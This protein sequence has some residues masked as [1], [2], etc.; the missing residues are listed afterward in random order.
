MRKVAQEKKKKYIESGFGNKQEFLDTFREAERL[1]DKDYIDYLPIPESIS[2]FF[3]L[4]KNL[5]ADARRQNAEVLL[6]GLKDVPWIT[7]IF[8][9]LGG[10]DVPLCVPVLVE[11]T[12]RNS[13][14]KHL[15][16]HQIYCP[17]HWPVSELHGTISPRTEK[18]Y[19]S[20]LSLVCDQRYDEEDMKHIIN[21]IND[22]YKVK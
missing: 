6:K 5:I 21:C 4:D 17:V 16:S 22:F 20:Q 18:I 1:L 7:P 8:P 10:N 12:L 3:N 11:D 13:L 19:N 9:K 2:F 15:I 14:R